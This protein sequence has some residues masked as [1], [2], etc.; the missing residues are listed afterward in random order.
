LAVVKRSYLVGYFRPL[1]NI[2]A[3]TKTAAPITNMKNVPLRLETS[4]CCFVVVGSCVVDGIVGVGI[5][6]LGGI[7]VVGGGVVVGT[8]VG[9]GAV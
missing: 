1:T 6:V 2:M 9:V 5:V 3:P 7:V 4:F 8:V